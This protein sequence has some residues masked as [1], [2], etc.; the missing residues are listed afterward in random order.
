MSEET[1][2]E[3]N[4]LPPAAL[5]ALAEAEERRKAAQSQEPRA[6]E[7]GGRD[8]P[9]PARYGDWEKKGIAIDF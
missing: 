3:Q 7:L 6:R 1:A 9:D 5:R 2:P 4:D 8:G